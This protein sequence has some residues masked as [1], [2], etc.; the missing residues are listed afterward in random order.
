MA[1]EIDR[2]REIYR[3]ADEGIEMLHPTSRPCIRCARTLYSEI[4]D[5]IEKRDYDVFSGR[6]GVSGRR[7][8]AVAGRS[9]LDSWRASTR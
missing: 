2:T 6:A 3:R 9:L 5:D 4:L 1:F 8:A 7:K